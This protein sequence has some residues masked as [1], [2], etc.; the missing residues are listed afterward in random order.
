MV[1]GISDRWRRMSCR[2]HVVTRGLLRGRRCGAIS[3][4]RTRPKPES[5]GR[6]GQGGNDSQTSQGNYMKSVPENRSTI[7][8]Q[9]GLF[10]PHGVSVKV[11]IGFPHSRRYERD[12]VSGS[13][14]SWM[15]VRETQY[16]PYDA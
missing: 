5:S 14:H 10:K 11:V 1:R 9:V 8:E 16:G 6:E 3:R 4:A 7:S 12:E 13:P 15:L 2:K